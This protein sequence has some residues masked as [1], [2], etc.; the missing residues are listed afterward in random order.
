MEIKSKK[1]AKNF[2][3]CHDGGTYII[4]YLLLAPN[5]PRLK[6]FIPC[7]ELALRL[8]RLERVSYSATKL[9]S[10]LANYL[11]SNTVTPD[12]THV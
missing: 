3:T 2:D 11:R 8:I 9:Q 4:T 10:D 7:D 5:P 6:L 12:G 1:R